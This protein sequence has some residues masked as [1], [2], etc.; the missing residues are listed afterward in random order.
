MTS[1][2]SDADQRWEDVCA[3]DELVPGEMKNVNVGRH[4]IVLIRDDDS[5]SAL[6]NVCPHEHCY[7]HTGELDD[8]AIVCPGHG[9]RFDA[10]TGEG[11]S[12][13]RANLGRYGV[14]VRDGRVLVGLRRR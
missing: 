10:H 5:V 13:R 12:P 9:W 8:G 2:G 4:S 3:E 14:Q 1:G 6:Q 11:I 7:L